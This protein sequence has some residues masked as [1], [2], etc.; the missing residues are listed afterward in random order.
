MRFV[1]I[2]AAVQDVFLSQ[3]DALDPV[4]EEDGSFYAELKMGGKAD[5]DQINFSTGGGATNAAVTFARQGLDSVFMGAIGH[6]IAGQA[7]VEDLKREGVEDKLFY[8]DEHNT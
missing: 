3:S 7:V 5:V 4:K 8:S 2:G 1:S 6:D